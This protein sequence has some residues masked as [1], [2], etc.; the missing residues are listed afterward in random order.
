MPFLDHPHFLF[1][2]NFLQEKGLKD[3][4]NPARRASDDA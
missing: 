3:Y 2:G 1:L 4:V